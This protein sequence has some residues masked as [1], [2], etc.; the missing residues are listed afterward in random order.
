VRAWSDAE[1]W[2]GAMGHRAVGQEDAGRVWEKRRREGECGWA[3]GQAK[4]GREGEKRAGPNPGVGLKRKEVRF[5]S[6][7]LSISK[8]FF[9]FSFQSQT[10]FYVIHIKSAYVCNILFIS[11]I[12]E[13]FW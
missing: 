12:N 8:F 13:Q 1:G 10:K 5:F 3:T 9:L 2:R 6:K 7:S 4:P 11:N